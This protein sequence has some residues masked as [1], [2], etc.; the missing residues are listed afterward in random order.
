M[1]P[2]EFRSR[3]PKARALDKWVSKTDAWNF[4]AIICGDYAVFEA[5]LRAHV[6]KNLVRTPVPRTKP[7]IRA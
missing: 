5:A 3:S 4:A 7:T 1:R 6:S 2:N